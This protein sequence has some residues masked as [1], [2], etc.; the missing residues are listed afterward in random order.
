MNTLNRRRFLGVG[1]ALLGAGALGLAG[2]G[3]DP[4]EGGRSGGRSTLQF[5]W[6]GNP[7][8]DKRTNA[9]IEAYE[10][11]NKNV[12][13]RPQIVNWDNYWTNLATKVA[14]GNPPDLIQMDYAYITEYSNRGSL[15]A[16][17]DYVPDK[18]NVEDFDES[19]ID[20]GTINGK[21]YGVSMGMNSVALLYNE[22]LLQE[23]GLEMPDWTMTWSE[24]F[25]LAREITRKTPDNVW[26]APN[27]MLLDVP[28]NCWLRQRGKSQFTEDGKLGFEPADMEEWF[29][30]WKDLQK[31]GVVPPTEV[32]LETTGDLADS[33]IV[34]GRTAFSYSWSNQ[35]AAF[36]AASKDD[37]K[38]HMFPQGDGP[39][40]KP[41]QFYKASM[42]LSVASASDH[43]EE[44]V[45]FV[46]ALL[47]DPEFAK[48]LGFE[49]GVPASQS[50]RD[51][52]AA[53]ANETE[54]AIVAYIEDIADKIGP[55]P[56]PEPQGSTEVGNAFTF[57]VE[58]AAYGRLSIKD[59]VD[60]FF[61]D[62]NKALDG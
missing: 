41:G 53:D 57:A 33:L 1:G 28:F 6:W 20:S 50:V 15:L 23:V 24:Y 16:L 9:A 8:R 59:A 26:G 19:Q 39:D 13:I 43:Q 51:A 21:L 40:A 46:N 5:A 44:A 7:E 17:D 18:L 60:K 36:N 31:E 3:P 55:T 37:I 45:A 27:G 14:G 22:T 52:L 30:I 35:L 54:K 2:C 62:A 49:R 4:S 61:T 29:T 25:D 47:T 32:E 11:K 38:I 56:P 10:Q 58:E 12:R 34:K 42:L 48:E